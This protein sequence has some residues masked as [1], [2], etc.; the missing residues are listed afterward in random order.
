MT[1]RITQ[2]YF[3]AL[4]LLLDHARGEVVQECM[5][6][7]AGWAVPITAGVEAGLS[8]LGAKYDRYTALHSC[9]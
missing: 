2:D 6:T 9:S 4:L 5:T 1:D 8:S 3:R 7:L